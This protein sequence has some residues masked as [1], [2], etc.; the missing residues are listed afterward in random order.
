MACP[1][2]AWQNGID[3]LKAGGA[4]EEEAIKEVANVFTPDDIRDGKVIGNDL[5]R[6]IK[7]SDDFNTVDAAV[8][9]ITD[10]GPSRAVDLGLQNDANVVKEF[11]K[12]GIDIVTIAGV[13]RSFYDIPIVGNNVSDATDIAKLL[14]AND[15]DTVKWVN[16]VIESKDTMQITALFDLL[17]SGGL[18]ETFGTKLPAGVIKNFDQAKIAYNKFYDNVY[19]TNPD[20]IRIESGKLTWNDGMGGKHTQTITEMG[21]EAVYNPLTGKM[22]TENSGFIQQTKQIDKFSKLSINSEAYAEVVKDY[23]QKYQDARGDTEKQRLQE[24][25]AK[26]INYALDS[27]IWTCTGSACLA[28]QEMGGGGSSSG[29]GSSG[30][31]Y[32]KPATTPSLYVES[33]TDADVWDAGTQKKIGRTNSIISMEPGTYTIETRKLGYKRVSRATTIGNYPINVTMNMYKVLTGPATFINSVGGLSK[34]TPEHALY[35]FS[36]YKARNTGALDWRTLAGELQ[37]GLTAPEQLTLSDVQY[38]WYLANGEPGRA[39]QLLAD[40]KVSLADGE[41]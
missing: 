38:I 13:S 18:T 22:E 14:I 28:A 34:L 24:D 16:T 30:S 27:P 41:E 15:P 6:V 33:N 21:G 2:N 12:R 4:T 7:Y 26:T 23:I 9:I 25:F 8:K 36:I 37:P 29:G 17:G 31:S 11:S 40:G 20:E 19:N 5:A 35:A 3:L 1:L 10:L 32:T 39:S